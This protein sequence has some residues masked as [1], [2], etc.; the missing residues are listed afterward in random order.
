[1]THD[2]PPVAR[3]LLAAL[4]DTT[5]R[6]LRH[7]NYRRYFLGQIVSFTGSW[8]Q[9]AAL[10]WL[11]YD[12]TGDPR[13]P[14]WLL[15]AQVGPTL[16]LGPWGGGLA[17]RVPKRRLVLTTQSAFL[18]HAVLLTLLVATDLATPP[19]VLGL[20]AVSGVIQAA[21]LPARLAF[22]PDLVPR[23]DLINAVGLNSL[24]FNSARALGP[25][26]AAGV[27]AATAAAAPHLPDGVNPV[28]AGA[29]ACFA[30]NAVSY[31]AVLLALRGID[32]P[33][34][35][36]GR[37]AAA[38]SAWDGVRYLRDHPAL[39]GLVLMT[40]V[41][42]VFGWPLLTTL[43]A[44]TRQHLGRDETTY[45]LL[46]SAVGAGALLGALTTATFGTPGRRWAFL[47]AGAA[48]AAA[49][50]LAVSFA[51]GAVPAAVGCA[52]AGFGLILYLSTGQS[53][54]QLAVPDATRGR[55]MALWAMTLSASAPL[56]HLLAG[57]AVAGFGVVPVLTGMAA[58]VGAAAAALGGMLAWRAR[59]G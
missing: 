47:T 36:G 14:A 33:G 6:S 58:G 17:D 25:A 56:G 52:A 28:T 42:C 49:G 16:L 38:G 35:A 51:D 18:A 26:L 30:L 54:V 27:F 2:V 48:A 24:L 45:S 4:R 10:M 59:R 19:L 23:E 8:M 3:G 46:V 9:S 57:H 22:V 53:T 13:W 34:E 31:L 41:V 7:R 1:M 15:V 20:M 5:F 29:V 50:I 12:R 44:Y 21:D 43:P 55:V 40:L 37:R 39:G 11:L 32:V